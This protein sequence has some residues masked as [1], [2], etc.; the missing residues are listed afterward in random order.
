ML[1]SPWGKYSVSLVQISQ[2]S[3]FNW[4]PWRDLAHLLYSV[5]LQVGWRNGLAIFRGYCSHHGAGALW[6]SSRLVKLHFSVGS[7]WHDL[8][9]LL[10]ATLLQGGFRYGPTVFNECYP[11]HTLGSLWVSSRSANLH[12]SAGSSWCDLAHLLQAALLQG[13]FRYW[14]AIF[15]EC[16]P[17]YG[18]VS[19]WVLCRSA[20]LHFSGEFETK[21]LAAQLPQVCKGGAWMTAPDVVWHIYSGLPCSKGEEGIHFQVRIQD[22]VKGGPQLLRPKVADVAKWSHATEACKLWPGSKARLRALEAFGFLMLKYAFSHILETL[23]LSF[24]TSI[25]IKIKI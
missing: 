24:L 15:R 17:H 9:H 19:P 8:A 7:S 25:L 23:F 12:F 5:L 3:F 18:L 20:K 14:P 6:V 22:L 10:F 16:S 2:S 4:W 11:H 1:P 21:R 13:G